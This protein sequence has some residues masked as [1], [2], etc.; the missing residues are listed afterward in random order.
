[1]TA[2]API[3][4]RFRADCEHT[5]EMNRRSAEK[6]G[7]RR[8]LKEKICRGYVPLTEVIDD[9]LLERLPIH[10]IC[11]LALTT[12]AANL[13]TRSRPTH[14]RSHR[15]VQIL[16]PLGLIG[17]EPLSRISQDR[18][19]EIARRITANRNSAYQIRREMTKQ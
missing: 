8:E 10:Y 1:M 3:K 15:V 5:K 2:E 12:R 17:H 16:R 7:A 14:R 9:P 19:M 13:D 18:K 11:R 4:H 6:R